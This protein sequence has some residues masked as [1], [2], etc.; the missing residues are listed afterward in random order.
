MKKRSKKSKKKSS[1]KTGSIK[2]IITRYLILIIAAIPGLAIFYIIFT[3]LTTY[4]VYFILDV[5]YE[6]VLISGE[7][8][9]ILLN[10]TLSIE[11]ISACI[12]G[13]AYY[14]LF[15]LN[16]STPGIKLKKRTKA[17]LFS[18]GVFLAVNIIRIIIL[19]ALAVSGSSYFDV[20]H[21]LFW[22]GLSTIIVVGIWFWEVKKFRIKKI[23]FY[24]D[25]KF[26]Y[27]AS[28]K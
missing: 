24:S 7:A 11:L 2:D 17:I 1:G 20:T 12:A 13:S 3:P 19:S 8:P 18:F 21:N 28:K 4:P 15:I 25:L 22:Y 9:V 27:K 16:L 14:L 26:L 10:N 6:A 23:P 5:L